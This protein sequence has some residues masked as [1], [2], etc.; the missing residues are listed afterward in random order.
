MTSPPKNSH[1]DTAADWLDEHGDALFR[2]ARQRVDS[3]EIAEDLVQ[4]TLIAGMGAYSKF[5][6][7][8]TVRTWLTGILRRKIIDHVRRVSRER[9]AK[10]EHEQAQE[11]FFTTNGHWR[12]NIGDWHGDPQQ[13]L[14]NKEF[15]RALDQCCAEM[16]GPV[17]NAFRLRELEQ[18]KTDEI[19]NVLEISP[20]NL[21]VRLHRA[22]LLLRECLEK[23][24]FL[25]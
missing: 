9:V 22:R 2:Y 11:S 3:A 14:E 19:C 7:R 10:R 5:E 4:D 20:T 16:T 6:G 23:R 24:W 17:A 18:M 8:S 1:S 15:W 13:S 25:P 21:S 12:A